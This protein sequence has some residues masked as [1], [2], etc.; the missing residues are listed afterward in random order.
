[1][2]RPAVKWKDVR[3]YCRKHGYEIHSDGGDAIIVAPK[4]DP[5]ARRARAPVR[6]GHRFSDKPNAELLP[7]HLKKLRDAFGIER[8]DILNR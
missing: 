5:A 2:A 3:R 6:I 4:N 8:E 7:I 1:M